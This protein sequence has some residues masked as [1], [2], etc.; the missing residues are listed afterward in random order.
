[1]AHDM[2]VLALKYANV[3]L[4]SDVESDARALKALKTSAKNIEDELVRR[5]QEYE[6]EKLHTA[7]M[8]VVNQL[9]LALRN[10]LVGEALKILV[11]Q[12]GELAKESGPGVV[13]VM[14]VLIS[15]ELATGQLEG[16]AGDLVD[17]PALME[18]LTLPEKL[19]N[20]KNDQLR[21]LT[22]QKLILEGNYTDAGAFLESKMT[23]EL[24]KDPP[25]STK[26]SSL[27]PGPFFALGSPLIPLQITDLVPM[28]P[29]FQPL[30]DELVIEAGQ[31]FMRR[32]NQLLAI[33]REASDLYFQCGFLSLL[34]G[35]ISTAKTQASSNPA[36]LASQRHGGFRSSRI[37]RRNT[38]CG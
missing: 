19:W 21:E 36:S 26:E 4:L 14:L 34:E 38:T 18:S 28:S 33:R 31:T 3:E 15:L 24:K 11:D 23:S 5:N 7:Q 20:Y 8:Q 29:V 1:M 25:L 2:M 32:Q 9:T 16:A 6:R 35:D 12:A 13:E 17:A 27:R 10:N 22:Y 37:P 30:R